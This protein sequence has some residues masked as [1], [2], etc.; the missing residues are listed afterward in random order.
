MTFLSIKKSHKSDSYSQKSDHN[1]PADK[2]LRI[3]YQPHFLHNGERNLFY[4]NN[5]C[6]NIP[7]LNVNFSTSFMQTV[8]L[9]GATLF[10]LNLIAR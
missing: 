10:L 9:M 3:V 7:A 6:F 4:V 2:N 8:S 1:V 5:I